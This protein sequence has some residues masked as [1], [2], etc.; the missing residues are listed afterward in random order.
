[1]SMSDKSTRV[2]K[3]E[4]LKMLQQAVLNTPGSRRI[5]PPG[6]PSTAPHKPEKKPA[7]T[8]APKS[9]GGRKLGRK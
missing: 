1:M 6:D 5:E 7:R 2:A 4:L 9:K 3:A 8:P